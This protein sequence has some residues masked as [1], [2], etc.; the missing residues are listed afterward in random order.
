LSDGFL[1]T[2]VAN[3]LRP[4]GTSPLLLICEHAS[5]AMPCEYQNLGI[6]PEML[7]SHI[8]FD[9]GALGLATQLS[10]LMDATLIYSGASR[11]LYDCNRPPEAADAMPS[12][13]EIHEIAGNINLT[14]EQKQQR[15]KQFY[16]PFR[17]LLTS[18]I[19]SRQNIE[20]IV[21]VHSFTPVYDGQVRAVEFGVL[22]DSDARFAKQVLDASASHTNLNT[23]LNQPYGPDDGVTHT[24]RVHGISNNLH[25][26]MLE[27][28]NDKLA[29]QALREKIATE[30]NPLLT[31]AFD[32]VRDSNS[33]VGL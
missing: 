29:T 16:Y 14:A 31:A 23:Q 25:N 32:R 5:N 15:V 21:T 3:I 33:G 20:G 4:Q 9:P 12:R 6:S 30:L 27:I 2:P 26:V 1:S 7:D 28:R 13:S 18:T 8:A 10:A 11:L 22:H 19:A 17:D 24:L